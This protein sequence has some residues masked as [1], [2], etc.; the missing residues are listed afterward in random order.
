MLLSNPNE[1]EVEVTLIGTGGGYGETLL[2]KIGKDDWVIIDSCINPNNKTPLSLEYLKNRC[3]G[4]VGGGGWGGG[5]GFLWAVRAKKFLRLCGLDEK[6]Y[7]KG[8]ISSTTEFSKCIDIVTSK[9]AYCKK[10]M[11]DMLLL[12]ADFKGL[13]FELYSLTPS[14]KTVADFETE[15]SELISEL[16]WK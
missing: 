8:S 1:N 12:R 16:K 13:N 2:L 6:K 7:H 10:A 14:P 4:G 3:I 9:G 5:G 11:H 15:L